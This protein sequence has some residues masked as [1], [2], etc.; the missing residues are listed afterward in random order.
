MRWWRCP[1]FTRPTRLVEIFIE[2][3]H[4]N[5]SPQVENIAPPRHII[6]IPSQPV[7]S[8]SL[9]L[10]RWAE[11]QQILI[12]YSLIW[13]DRGLNQQSTPFKARTITITSLMQLLKLWARFFLHF[14]R[15]TRYNFV[16]DLEMSVLVLVCN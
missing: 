16:Q 6:L 5:N 12:I 9:M 7:W 13:P 14:V 4:W 10:K 15:C 8:Y 1:L 3:A 11:K 2:Q